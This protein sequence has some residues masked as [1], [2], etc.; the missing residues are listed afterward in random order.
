ME[1]YVTGLN[2]ERL[3]KMLAEENMEETKR[4]VVT[5]LLATEEEKLSALIRSEDEKEKGKQRN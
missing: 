1:K 2:I 4:K 3:R 5:Q